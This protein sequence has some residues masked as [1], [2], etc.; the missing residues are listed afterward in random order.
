MIGTLKIGWPLIEE[1]FNGVGVG[2]LSIRAA[3]F[4]TIK[5]LTNQEQIYKTL[6]AK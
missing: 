4:K 6:Y 2:Y 1:S 5:K 3:V